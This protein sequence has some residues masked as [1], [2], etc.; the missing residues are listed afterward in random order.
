MLLHVVFKGSLW[1]DAQERTELKEPLLIDAQ[2]RTELKELNAIITQCAS[3]GNYSAICCDRR[4]SACDECR[5]GREECC[6]GSAMQQGMISGLADKLHM[7]FDITNEMNFDLACPRLLCPNDDGQAL[8]IL[9]FFGTTLPTTKNGVICHK[10]SHKSPIKFHLGTFEDV[11]VDAFTGEV[12][13]FEKKFLLL[14]SYGNVRGRTF[15]TEAKEIVEVP[16]LFS[17]KQTW[18]ESF[19]H[20]TIEH[21]WRLPFAM[22]FLEQNP[23]VKVLMHVNTAED[24]FHTQFADILG[25]KDRLVDGASNV[26]DRVLLVKK[27]HFAWIEPWIGNYNA[28]T[29]L[30][31][32]RSAAFKAL[33][34]DQLPMFTMGNAGTHIA[35]VL[36]RSGS[37]VLNQGRSVANHLAMMQG[38][39]ESFPSLNFIEFTGSLHQAEAIRLF[40]RARLVIGPHGSGLTNI[41]W[42]TKGAVILEMMHVGDHDDSY[43]RTKGTSTHGVYSLFSRVLGLECWVLPVH[44]ASMITPYVVSIP[45]IIAITSKAL[46]L[47]VHGSYRNSSILAKGCIKG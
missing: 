26:C 24:S 44:N 40:A 31:L 5:C 9:K 34:I 20:Y 17:L 22:P 43:T 37:N 1:I 42:C 47:Q 8:P 2:K 45:K 14:R 41:L 33:R 29:A 23:Q 4:L 10:E 13:S 21:L 38:L 35:I 19:Y 28:P 46:A 18:T 25:V 6:P 36:A 11:A 15:C 30:H 27:F 3:G 39:V 32:L 16:E 7:S 12:W